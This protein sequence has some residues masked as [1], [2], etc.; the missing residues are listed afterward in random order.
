M[1][2]VNDPVPLHS[3]LANNKVTEQLVSLLGLFGRK[4]F[5]DLEGLVEAAE[6]LF[7]HFVFWPQSRLQGS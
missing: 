4:G 3:R 5:L 2:L 6:L 1:H 7:S